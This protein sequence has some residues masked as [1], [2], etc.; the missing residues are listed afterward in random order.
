MRYAQ[1]FKNTVSQ[2]RQ[3]GIGDAETDAILLFEFCFGLTRTRLYLEGAME[4]PEESLEHFMAVLGRRLSREPLNYITGTREFWSL[5]FAVS[6][7]VLVPRAETEF[8]VESVLKTLQN[9]ISTSHWRVLDMCTGSGV[10][11]VVL[12][13]ELGSPWVI[14]VDSSTDAL[15]VAERNVKK[16]GLEKHITL[17]CSDLFSAIAETLRF[18]VIV[19]NP[20]YVA[21][22][23]LTGLQAEV[24]DWEP[25][26]ALAAGEKGLDV[27]REIVGQAFRYLVPGGWLFVEIGADQEDSVHELFAGQTGREYEDVAVIPDWSGRPRLLRARKR[28]AAK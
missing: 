5:D 10:I 17:V 2:F 3:A 13:R 14:A 12:A 1:L 23:D 28:G 27:I 7:A 24:R 4:V 21:E 8:V 18:E 11:A 26:Q 20:P 15:R 16:F 9:H 6:P 19:S 22:S 25:R